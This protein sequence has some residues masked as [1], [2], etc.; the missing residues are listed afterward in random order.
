MVREIF[1]LSQEK[2]IQVVLKTEFSLVLGIPGSVD[3]NT[4]Q[5]GRTLSADTLQGRGKTAAIT[6]AAEPDPRKD[7]FFFFSLIRA[8][9]P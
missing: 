8:L 3:S 6:D 1:P 4:Q 7:F 5:S 2:R 9:L